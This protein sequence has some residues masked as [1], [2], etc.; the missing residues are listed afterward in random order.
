VAFNPKPGQDEILASTDPVLVVLGGAGTGKTTTAAA[1]VRKVL[2]EDKG[3]SGAQK[4]ALFLSFSRAA[5]SQIVD[6]TK[7]VL[8]DQAPF[9][10]ITTFHAFAWQIIRHWGPVVGL[11]DPVL[12]A[13]S[14]VKLFGTPGGLVFADLLP[15]ALELVKVPAIGAHLR[16]RWSIVVCDEFQD[17]DDLQFELIRKIRGEARLVFL[18]DLNQ[19]IY[20]NLPGV[21]GVGPG[22]IEAALALQGARQIVLP[23]VSHRDPTNVLPAAAA[24]IRRREF[25][26]AAVHAALESQMLEICHSPDRDGEGRVVAL[27]V[28]RL[29]EEGYESVGVFSHHVDAT[30]NL[31]DLLSVEGIAHE[32]V[33]LSDA[34][35]SAMQAQFEMLRFSAEKQDSGL[36]MRA[37]GLFV[38]S[39][40]RGQKAPKLAL[41]IVGKAEAPRTLETRLNALL[42]ELDAATCV[43]DSL[44]VAEQVPNSIGL[45]RGERTW[46]Q[47]F[48]VFTSLLG[49]R[50]YRSEGFPVGGFGSI[51]AKLVDEQI[52]L[53]TGSDVTPTSAVQLMGLYQS[54]GREADATVIVLREGDFYGTEPEPM[55]DGSKLLYVVLTRARRKTVVLTVGAALPSL[56]EPLALLSAEM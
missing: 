3:G 45:V 12:S 27:L 10:E 31:S 46:S 40:E 21:V 37:L 36:V 50:L 8:G 54:K 18:G 44:R 5:V 2:D 41:Q 7:D 13:P 34:T 23:D 47:G 33:G 32:I 49:P 16:R 35:T 1:L 53:L 19:C 11:T 43:A 42:E 9:V 17:T 24:S 30:A 56:V 51:E 20:R 4:R 26:H 52:S 39:L 29:R 48:R 38:T 22:R 28:R 15:I 55:E 14:E 25:G 6:R